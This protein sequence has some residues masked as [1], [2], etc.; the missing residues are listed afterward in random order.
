LSD[1]IF[2]TAALLTT[3]VPEGSVLQLDTAFLIRIGIQWLNI[4]F[5][6]FI[7][8]YVLYKPVKKFMANRAERIQKE[9]DNAHQTNEKAIEL[10]EN[11]DNLLNNIDKER[12]DILQKAYRNS[13]EKHDQILFAA[14]EEAKYILQKADEEIK[15]ERDNAAED[16]K[17]QIIELS[18]YMAG[19]FVEVSID[20]Q[21]QDKYIDDAIA[22]WSDQTWQV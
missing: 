12:E 4:A 3:G 8:I 10:K 19:R 7:M 11:Y 13:M 15:A 14:R 6:T 20:K 21:T 17:R 22:E 18:T 1:K 2:A 16:I 9:I 5:L